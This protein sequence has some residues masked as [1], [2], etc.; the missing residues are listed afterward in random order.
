M[1]GDRFDALTRLLGQA[2]TRRAATAAAA[3]AAGAVLTAPDGA[4][5][6]ER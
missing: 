3:A 2:R 1:D 6:S 4:V 5:A